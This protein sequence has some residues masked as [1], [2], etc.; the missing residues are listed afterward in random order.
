[1][2]IVGLTR[3]KIDSI[4]YFNETKEISPSVVIS[5]LNDS[6][7]RPREN[8]FRKYGIDDSI[9]ILLRISRKSL[10]LSSALPKMSP[11]ILDEIYIYYLYLIYFFFCIFQSVDSNVLFDILD[12]FNNRYEFLY[13]FNIER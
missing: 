1:M 13:Q 7:K 6:S 11:R 8:Q 9:S 10:F 2:I 12:S 5:I 3:N 4:G